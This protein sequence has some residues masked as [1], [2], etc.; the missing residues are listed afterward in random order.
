M[1]PPK[2]QTYH[3][4]CTSLLLSST[5]TLSRLPRRTAPSADSISDSALILPLPLTPPLLTSPSPSTTAL[6]STSTSNTEQGE[7]GQEAE[8]GGA[9]LPAEGYTVLLG[10]TGDRKT[11]IIRRE[12]GFEKRILYRCS[13]CRLVVGYE[14]QLPHHGVDSGTTGTG[15]DID[16]TSG[17]GKGR[18]VDAGYDGKVLYILPGGVM[19]TDVLASGRRIGEEDVGFSVGG[20]RGSV[21]VFE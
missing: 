14:L 6:P 10:L 5:H 1:A 8:E 12:D 20:G 16:S 4:I 11:T 21:A 2:I 7:Q 17:K 9:S 15:M 3:C 13:R 18:E 19:S